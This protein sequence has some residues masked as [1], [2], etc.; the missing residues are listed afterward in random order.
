MKPNFKPFMS[1]KITVAIHLDAFR[2][3][4]VTESDSPFLWTLK[5]EGTS[6]SLTPTFGFEPD[7]GC[8]GGLYQRNVMMESTSGARWRIHR[9][10]SPDLTR[11]VWQ[12]SRTD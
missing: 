12:V 1:S 8:F 9:L 11:Q 7:A 10:P 4:Y 5:S 6:G 2:Y 3:D